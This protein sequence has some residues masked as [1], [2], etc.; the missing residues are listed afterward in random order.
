MGSDRLC[1][2]VHC[3]PDVTG[4]RGFRHFTKARPGNLRAT[5]NPA[6][7]PRRGF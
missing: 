1:H 7:F 5:K 6:R 2:P 3:T 4:E